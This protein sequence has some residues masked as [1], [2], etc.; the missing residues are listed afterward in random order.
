MEVQYDCIFNIQYGLA[1]A[2]SIHY[3]LQKGKKTV[4][5]FWR[6]NK[7]FVILVVYINLDRN[8]DSLRSFET[9]T[10]FK[11]VFCILDDKEVSYRLF[12]F[13]ELEFNISIPQQKN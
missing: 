11:T 4:L 13:F 8:L 3:Y 6:D 1:E 12:L 7:A 5:L 2:H 10:E 9:K